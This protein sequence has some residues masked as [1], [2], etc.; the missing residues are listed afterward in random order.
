MY[1]D[2]QGARKDTKQGIRWLSLAADKGQYQDQAVFDT[3]LFKG[4]YLARGATGRLRVAAPKAPSAS[5]CS[6]PPRCSPTI[7]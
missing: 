4:Q 7:S 6:S 2:G 1:L 5:P 3:L